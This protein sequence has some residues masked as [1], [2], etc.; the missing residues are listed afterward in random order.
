[1][2]SRRQ[3][4]T[5]F[6]E[7]VQFIELPE[8]NFDWSGWEDK[9]DAL[10]EINHTFD[11]I[12]QDQLPYGGEILFLPTGPFQETSL[13]SGWGDEFC[14]L[15]DRYDEAMVAPSDCPCFLDPLGLLG[16]ETYFGS[17][18]N[19]ADVSTLVC[20]KCG[21][22][23]VRYQ[24][25]NEGISRSGRWFLAAVDGPIE[26]LSAKEQIEDAVEYWCGGSYFDGTTS[27]ASGPIHL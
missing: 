19:F 1:M 10:E 4:L 5:V 12:R 17:D 22:S 26:R 7:V 20:S 13:S 15:A 2:A 16:D 21:Q 3:L 14:A 27:L 8:N 9:E 25:E 23:W 24:Y 11:R 18:T 6:K